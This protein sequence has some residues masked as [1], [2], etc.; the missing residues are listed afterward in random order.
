MSDQVILQALERL[1]KRLEALEAKVEKL[2]E[3]ITPHA[4]AEAFYDM[5]IPHPPE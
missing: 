3:K 2:G 4:L 5:P 1:E